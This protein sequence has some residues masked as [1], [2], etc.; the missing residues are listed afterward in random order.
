MDGFV[1]RLRAYCDDV[2]QAMDRWKKRPGPGRRHGDGRPP[3]AVDAGSDEFGEWAEFEYEGV[4][5]R[6][7][8]IPP[9]TFTMG[10]PVNELGRLENEGPQHEVTIGAGF[11]LFATPVT[12][13]LYEAVIGKN[14]TWFK[15]AERPVQKVSWRDAQ[16]FLERLNQR[17][18][19]L[20]LTLPSEAQW[21]YACR[22]GTRTATYAGDLPDLDAARV[23][24]V[25]AWFDKNSGRQTRPV[26]QKRPNAWGLYD[27]LGNVWEWCADHW[28]ASY[29]G[30]PDD[31]SAWID[32]G[33]RDS[34]LRVIRG[35]SWLVEVRYCRAAYRGGNRAGV[36]RDS[37]GFRPA[38]GQ[39]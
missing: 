4:R 37:Q 15:G 13:A 25:I 32:E 29:D 38:R 18:P 9:G 30:A 8:W 1:D 33:A 22:A 10:S 34:A 23:L 24:E 20:D 35:G 7:R 26:G 3:W 31:G 2:V 16:V 12:Q 14:R 11:W 21:E 39:G 28:H 27:M 5:Q 36:R 19:G 17:V 6:L